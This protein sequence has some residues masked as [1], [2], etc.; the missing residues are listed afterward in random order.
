MLDNFLSNFDNPYY[1]TLISMFF[2]HYA[3]VLWFSFKLPI[4]CCFR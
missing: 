2:V 4:L 1:S 3:L